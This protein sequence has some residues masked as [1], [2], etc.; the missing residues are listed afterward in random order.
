[1]LIV[2]DLDIRGPRSEVMDSNTFLKSRVHD[3]ILNI[4]PDYRYMRTGYYV[5][6]QAEVMDCP[7][8]P[9][10]QDSLDAYRTPIFLLR[11]NKAGLPTSP[12]IVSDNVKD[13]MFEADFPMVLFPLHPA[14][15]GAY[16]V[17]NSE[18][19]LYRTVKSLGMN[20]KYPVCAENL[21]GRLISTKS[22]L[23]AVDDPLVTKLAAGVYE[24]F[25]LPICRLYLQV[26]GEEA[27][28]CSLSPVHPEELTQRE[29]R[30]LRDRIEA[31]GKHFG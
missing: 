3:T 12:Y 20:Q 11:A 13:I 17:V 24:E 28:L 30:V 14:S 2:S 8:R 15:N 18:G 6:M 25:R 10:C 7:V 31:T 23:G 1:M 16:K 26:L 9:S 29:L 27:Y 19:S 21:F 22:L 4:Q 5:S